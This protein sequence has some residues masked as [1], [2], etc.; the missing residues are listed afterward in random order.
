[1]CVFVRG[2]NRLIIYEDTFG[3][4][5]PTVSCKHTT[6]SWEQ[7]QKRGISDPDITGAKTEGKMSFSIHLNDDEDTNEEKEILNQLFE[8]IQ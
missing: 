8:Q 3:F 2:Q 1:M 6:H 4:R 5:L 7:A